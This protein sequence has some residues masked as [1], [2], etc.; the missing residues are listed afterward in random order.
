MAVRL[1]E[2]SEAV[3]VEEWVERARDVERDIDSA[4]A[5]VRQAQE[6]GRLNLRRHAAHRV[7]ATGDFADLLGRLEQAAADTRSM[8]R[9]IGRAGGRPEHWD[10]RFRDAWIDLLARTGAAVSDADPDAIAAVRADI[11]AAVTELSERSGALRPVQG[12][13]LVNLRNIAEA[14]EEVAAAQPVR[15][16]A[17]PRRGGVLPHSRV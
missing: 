17:P 6:S 7:R 4:W 10:P 14:M 2:G 12:A 9:T 1:R 5:A 13:L 3:D 15:S 11:D 16:A 8:A